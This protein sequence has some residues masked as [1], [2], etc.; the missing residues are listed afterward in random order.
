VSKR[1]HP[2]RY[3]P[4][5]SITDQWTPSSISYTL[6]DESEGIR[7][8]SCHRVGTI[9]SWSE[10]EHDVLAR[11]GSFTYHIWTTIDE[12]IDIMSDESLG[13]EGE[14]SFEHYI[15]KISSDYEEIYIF[16]KGN[17]GSFF[18]KNAIIRR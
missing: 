4:N 5:F 9:E 2:S 6:D 7:S 11:L 12:L 15:E 13:D 14:L 16:Y 8:K 10:L 3:T 18:K 1:D 17:L